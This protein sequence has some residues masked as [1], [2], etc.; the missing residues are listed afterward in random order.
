V[1]VA[2]PRRLSEDD[3]RIL[4]QRQANLTAL[5]KHASWPELEAEVERQI[6]KIERQTVIALGLRLGRYGKEVN[7]REI[8]YLRGFISGIKWLIAVPTAA[9]NSLEQ[10]LQRQGVNLEGDVSGN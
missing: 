7:Q 1:A 8:D 5:S 6:V 4:R 2:R 9:E 3:Q 10:Y